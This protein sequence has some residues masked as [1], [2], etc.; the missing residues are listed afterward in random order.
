MNEGDRSCDRTCKG[1]APFCKLGGSKALKPGKRGSKPGE[2]RKLNLE[3]ERL[4]R[5]HNY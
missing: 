3:Q 2:R 4:V 1:L 5:K